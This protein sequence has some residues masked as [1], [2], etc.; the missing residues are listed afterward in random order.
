MQAR[1]TVFL[2]KSFS[3]LHA[4]LQASKTRMD[5]DHVKII[6]FFGWINI[7]QLAGMAAKHDMPQF[8]YPTGMRV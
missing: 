8:L 7:L 5:V 2:G 3:V 1:I 4:A 6:Y